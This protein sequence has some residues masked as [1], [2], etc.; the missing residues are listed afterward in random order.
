M[1]YARVPGFIWRSHEK[2]VRD[3]HKNMKSTHCFTLCF[4]SR[5]IEYALYTLQSHPFVDT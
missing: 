5:L 4:S 2:T 1:A 3:F